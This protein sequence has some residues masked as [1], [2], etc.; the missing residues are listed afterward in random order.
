M[1]THSYQGAQR[2]RVTQKTKETT[3]AHL[4]E[5][6][7]QE[8]AAAGRQGANINDISKAA[9]F[10]E[11]TI[12]NYFPSKDATF[13]AV[14]EEACERAAAGAEAAPATAST[15]HRLRVAV[16]S[17]VE[18]ARRHDAFARVLVREALTADAE[19]YPQIVMAARPFVSKVA[20][21]LADGISRGDIRARL[22]VEQLALTVVGLT[23]LLLAQH[24]RSDWPSFEEIPDFVVDLLLDGVG[25]HGGDHA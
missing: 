25:N 12:Y 9:G 5:A 11:G 2:A 21:I 7:A 18:W 17:D 24:W 20:T 16:A 8:F 4:L 10:A 6:A 3:R 15:R 23:L 1:G 22:G 14:V 13:L 19:Q